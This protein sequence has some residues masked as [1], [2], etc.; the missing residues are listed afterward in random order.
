[1]SLH[2]TSVTLYVAVWGNESVLY[3]LVAAPSFLKV[4]YYVFFVLMV[5]LFHGNLV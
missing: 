2:L 4:M 1:M 5:V 3:M